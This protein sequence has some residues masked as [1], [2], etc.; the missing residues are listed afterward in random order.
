[1][2][3]VVVTHRARDS[4]HFGTKGGVGSGNWYRWNKRATVEDCRSVDVRRWYR[5]MLPLKEEL[6][7]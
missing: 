7:G 6:D 2:R 3:L 5:E 4:R 1:M